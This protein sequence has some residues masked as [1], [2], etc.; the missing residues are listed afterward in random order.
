MTVQNLDMIQQNN[1]EIMYV[2]RSERNNSN[3]LHFKHAHPFA[4]LFYITSGK[5]LFIIGEEEVEVSETDLIYIAPNAEHTELSKYDTPMEYFV[6]GLS[7]FTVKNKTHF[8]L[9]YLVIQDTKR[10]YPFYFYKCFE[11]HTQNYEHH[12]QI[13]KNLISSFLLILQR[14]NQLMIATEIPEINLKSTVLIKHY[15]DV[16][17]KEDPSL[18]DLAKQFHMSKYY[19]SHQFK[20]DYGISPIK[21]WNTI[22]L[23]NVKE[24]LLSSN[25]SIAEISEMLSYTSQSYLTQVFKKSTGISPS[26]YRKNHWR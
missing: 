25:F 10:E 2:H 4:E 7:G 13:I 22:R 8:T 18:E 11:E 1:L 6:I 16:N 23:E 5:G 12:D 26:Q 14:E 21:Y 19:L 15:I 24:L 3:W 17:F 20:K 9:P